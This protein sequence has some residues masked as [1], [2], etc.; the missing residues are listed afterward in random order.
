MADIQYQLKPLCVH[1]QI[2]KY[3]E[4]KNERKNNGKKNGQKFSI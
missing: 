1:T 4:K 3:A 2:N